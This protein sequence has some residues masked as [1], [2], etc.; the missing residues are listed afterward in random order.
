VFTLPSGDV[1]FKCPYGLLWG[2]VGKSRG[3]GDTIA[4]ITKA[5]TLGKLP[6]CRR[7]TEKQK[8]LNRF[9]PYHKFKVE[10]E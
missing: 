6:S 8:K 4:K 9:L 2:Y 3:L 7:C 1:D 10:D 5:V